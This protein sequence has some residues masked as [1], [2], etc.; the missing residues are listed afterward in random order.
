M[1]ARRRR[2]PA[3]W[4]APLALIACAGAVYTVVRQGQ[5]DGGAASPAATQ[6]ARPSTGSAPRTVATRRRRAYTVR[7]G[8]TLSSIAVKTGVPLETIQR[9]NPK[10]DAQALRAG[11]KVKLAAASP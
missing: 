2:N 1:A 10:L 11:Q 3:R 4:L 6:Q 7:P 9:L 5:G 8:D